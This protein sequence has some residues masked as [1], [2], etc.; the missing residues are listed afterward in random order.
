MHTP[1]RSATT[2]PMDRRA[3]LLAAASAAVAAA[4]SSGDGGGGAV[5]AGPEIEDDFMLMQA[6]FADGLRVPTTF[7][8]G[9]PA[10]AP[11]IF[12]GGDGLP[13]VNGIPASVDMLLTSPDGA[14]QTYT[15][16][17]HDAGIPTPH[18]PLEFTPAVTGSYFME[19]EVRG[20]T[21]RIEFLVAEPGEVGL[22]GPG[23]MLRPVDTPTFDNAHG[24]DP[25]CTR[26][27]PCPF[28][29]R[30]LT[31]VIGNGLPTALMIATPGF[32]R[33]SICGPVVE[34]LIELNPSEM[35]VVHGEVFTEPDRLDE[36]S[37][38]TTLVGPIV[39]TYE[40]DFEPSLIVA[41]SS[42][43]V[44]ARLDFTFDVTEMEAALATVS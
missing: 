33:T 31:D 3:F 30:N 21:Q 7:A 36:V 41:D 35:N 22:V 23:D 8:A 20:E 42:G 4:C 24:Y 10:R 1:P 6:G 34:L 16:L 37:D 27:E 11:F 29:E 44:T 28:H 14:T 17:R 39:K 32:C 43:V 2:Q 40:M 13:A 9:S 5:A 26:F 25:I 18:Y 19:V 15:A 12:F 38:F